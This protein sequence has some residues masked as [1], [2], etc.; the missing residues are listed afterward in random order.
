MFACHICQRNVHTAPVSEAK[1]VLNAVSRQIGLLRVPDLYETTQAACRPVFCLFDV[2]VRSNMRLPKFRFRV[3][4]PLKK[5]ANT[6]VK[7]THLKRLAILN[8]YMPTSVL[9]HKLT[10]TLCLMPAHI[11]SLRLLGW[12]FMHT[13]TQRN[14]HC[15]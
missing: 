6:P 14:T 3:N 2:E 12:L 15:S 13:H 1:N 9:S 7:Y 5:Y 4:N 11:F 8:F 10:Q